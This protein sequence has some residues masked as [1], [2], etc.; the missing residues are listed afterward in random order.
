MQVPFQNMPQALK[1][2]TNTLSDTAFNKQA[3]TIRE[4]LKNFGAISLLNA[5]GPIQLALEELIDSTVRA[6]FASSAL[7]SNLEVL[8]LEL[9]SFVPRLVSAPLFQELPPAVLTSINDY[10]AKHP[11]LEMPATFP[12]LVGLVARVKDSAAKKGKPSAFTRLLSL[13]TPLTAAISAANLRPEKGKKAKTPVSPLFRLFPF[14][15]TEFYL[16]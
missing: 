14:S 6:H 3:D 16:F 11:N 10:S 15:L 8:Q 12:R 1:T 2:T 5:P 13:L 4:A 9:N 7:L